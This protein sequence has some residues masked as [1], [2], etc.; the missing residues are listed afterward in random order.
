MSASAFSLSVAIPTVGF[1]VVSGEPVIGGLR[2]PD[3]RHLFCP[4]CMSWM[5]TRFSPEFVNVRV[6]MLDDVSWFK[7][8]VETWT[9]TKLPWVN[10]AAV[11][12]YPEFPPMEE[13]AKLTTE[14]SQSLSKGRDQ[15]SLI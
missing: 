10:T 3:L 5:F 1:E 11:H 4:K 6:T 7:P 9:S 14:F 12:S 15:R 13:Y 8:F 2:N